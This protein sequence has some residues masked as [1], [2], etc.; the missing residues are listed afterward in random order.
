MARETNPFNRIKNL[1]PDLQKLAKIRR[2]EYE[3]GSTYVNVSEAFLP[4]LTPEYTR[5]YDVM[6][7]KFDEM[8]K[9]IARNPK[10]YQPLNLPKCNPTNN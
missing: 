6:D 1:P 9:F 2:D 3:K 4:R 5:W 10:I 7:G 8:R